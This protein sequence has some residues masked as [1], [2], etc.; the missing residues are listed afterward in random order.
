MFTV[1]WPIKLFLLQHLYLTEF[2]LMSC[3]TRRW[4]LSNSGTIVDQALELTLQNSCR[5]F[6]YSDMRRLFIPPSYDLPAVRTLKEAEKSYWFF[7]EKEECSVITRLA[8][9]YQRVCVAYGSGGNENT[10]YSWKKYSAILGVLDP[11]WTECGQLD[12]SLLG[13]PKDT[14]ITTN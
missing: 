5:N 4:S 3:S 8:S 14:S 10:Q 9:V 6:L 1:Y 12:E 2:D 7:L 13:Q 11:N